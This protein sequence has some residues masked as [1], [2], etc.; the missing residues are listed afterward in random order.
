[1]TDGVGSREGVDAAG[2]TEGA[3]APGAAGTSVGLE[4]PA[5]AD[6]IASSLERVDDDVPDEFPRF[7][8][9]VAVVDGVGSDDAALAADSDPDEPDDDEPDDDE[10]ADFDPD[11]PDDDEPDD[12]EG[13]GPD[14]EDPLESDCSAIATGVLAIAAPMP[15]AT[16]NAPTRPTYCA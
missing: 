14:D 16:A 3:A 10:P 9:G 11:E 2:V 4:L 13:D 8:G 6:S 7:A 12:D 1:M 5:P 15:S